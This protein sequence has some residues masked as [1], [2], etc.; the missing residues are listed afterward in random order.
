MEPHLACNVTE[1]KVCGRE[2]YPDLQVAVMTGG[3]GAWGRDAGR[4]NE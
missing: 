2:V 3:H 1:D 4:R